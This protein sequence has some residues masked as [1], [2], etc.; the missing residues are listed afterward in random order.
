MDLQFLYKILFYYHKLLK[1]LIIFL[2]NILFQI[3][4]ILNLIQIMKLFLY[5]NY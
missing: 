2:N 4:Y 3:D 1:S 5:I